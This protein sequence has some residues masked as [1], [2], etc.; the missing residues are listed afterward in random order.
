MKIA[1][2]KKFILLSTLLIFLIVFSVLYLANR[3]SA[4]PPSGAPGSTFGVLKVSNNLLSIGTSTLYIGSPSANPFTSTSSLRVQGQDAGSSNSSLWVENSANSPAMVIRND[5][6]MSIGTSTFNSNV[7]GGNGSDKLYV[8]GKIIAKSI[9]ANTI[10]GNIT[11]SGNIYA[12][13][14]A[15]GAFGCPDFAPVSGPPCVSLPSGDYT[16]PFKLGVGATST[17]NLFGDQLS[18]FGS[19]GL[20]GDINF[21]GAPTARYIRGAAASGVNGGALYIQG[22]AGDGS[23]TNGGDLYLIG[24]DSGYAFNPS[25][26]VIIRTVS[27]SSGAQSYI[28]FQ[29]NGS[30]ERMRILRSGTIGIGTTVPSSTLHVVGTFRANTS[31]FMGNVI[32][33]TTGSGVQFSDGS[34]LYTANGLGLS[35]GVANYLSRWSSASTLT[36]ST[37]FQDPSANIGIGTATP[38]AKLHVNGDFRTTSSTVSGNAYI[39]GNVTLGDASSDAINLTGSLVSNINFAN[40]A[41]WSINV[42]DFAGPGKSLSISAGSSTTGDAWGVNN[43]GDIALKAGAGYN[44]NST[45]NGVGG[46]VLIQGGAAPGYYYPVGGDVILDSGYASGGAINKMGNLIFRIGGTEQMRVNSA[47]NI[48]IGTATP[49]YK[50]HV[51]D[52]FFASSSF[53]GNVVVNGPFAVNLTGLVLSDEVGYKRIQSF[54][55][56][57]LSINPLGNNVGIGSTNPGA[58]LEIA[59]SSQSALRLKK[60]AGSAGSVDLFVAVSTASLSPSGACTAVVATAQCLAGW[61]SAGTNVGCAGAAA[62]GNR[63]LCADFGD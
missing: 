4:G 41:S 9:L 32:V 54:D 51:A 58:R 39:N 48:G 33:S 60:T 63:A 30:T 56:E 12:S 62:S 24:G 61:N 27:D 55:T 23:A 3:A 13:Q 26:K 46:N 38:G 29:T 2:S 15:P 31:T 28:S 36:T 6:A 59:D 50:L 16:F 37:L 7:P 45:R 49:S 10:T 19:T 22:G 47:G 44:V 34:I 5:G 17:V 43:G 57:P 42:A 52:S 25:G 14:I 18:V 1:A 11:I 21:Y 40:S 35:G 8:D 53:S 20:N